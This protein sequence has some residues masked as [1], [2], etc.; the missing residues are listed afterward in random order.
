MKGTHKVFTLVIA[1]AVIAVAVTML[2]GYASRQGEARPQVADVIASRL[3]Q[4]NIPYSSV[5]ITSQSPLMVEVVVTS[6]GT[7]DQP[8]ES[9]AWNT[10]IAQREVE[11]SYLSTG[12]HID[13]V[14][15][16]VVG[17][18]GA[19]YSATTLDIGNLPSQFLQ[20]VVGAPTLSDSAMKDLLG[21]TLDTMGMKVI[22]LN[23]TSGMAVRPNTR[24]VELRLSTPTVETAD[25][26][27]SQLVYYMRSTLNTL[28]KSG[29]QIA[30][31]RMWVV[32]GNGK[33]LVDDVV[34]FE[35][36]SESWYVDRGITSHWWP[37]PQ[38]VPTSSVSP[39][40]SPLL[41]K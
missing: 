30:I 3:S 36:N 29:A 25:K 7:R 15:I 11:L 10:Y 5:R 41:P 40:Q 37:E 13:K 21:R 34:D 26:V 22:S 38:A 33:V 35:A 32:D 19:Q 9:D 2:I 31:L 6:T 14:R 17:M 20:P 39:L 23:V 1:F 16:V 8:D 24:L 28:N 27:I 12:V 4:I 18:D